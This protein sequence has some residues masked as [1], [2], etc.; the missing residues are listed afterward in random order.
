LEAIGKNRPV[1]VKVNI[2]AKTLE[3][4]SHKILPLYEPRYVTPCVGTW[5]G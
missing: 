5:L 4:V 1:E 2:G 3:A